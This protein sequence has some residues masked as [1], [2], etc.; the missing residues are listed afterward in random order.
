MAPSVPGFPPH[1]L[2]MSPLLGCP[3]LPWELPFLWWVQEEHQEAASF[4]CHKNSLAPPRFFEGQRQHPVRSDW[5]YR[6]CCDCSQPGVGVPRRGLGC[7]GWVSGLSGRQ[8]L[9]IHSRMMPAWRSDQNPMP[10]CAA[11]SE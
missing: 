6:G 2:G 4:L 1:P 8:M 7:P 11:S 3:W 10:G 9:W 5:L